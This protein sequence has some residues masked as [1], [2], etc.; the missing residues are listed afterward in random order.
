[1][2]TGLSMLCISFIIL[3][4]S[5]NIAPKSEFISFSKSTILV[6]S[7]DSL[8]LGVVCTLSPSVPVDMLS[9]EDFSLSSSSSF[10]S[11]FI[12]AVLSCLKYS[13]GV[14]F[15][16]RYHLC[17]SLSILPSCLLTLN[18]FISSTLSCALKC[19]FI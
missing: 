16:N 13:F 6:I 5:I 8:S 12:S 11:I 10:C 1:M 7:S 19:S 3:F 18:L 2:Y 14:F 15:S 17:S 4:L 9:S